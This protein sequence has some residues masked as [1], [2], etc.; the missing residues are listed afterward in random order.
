M[1]RVAILLPPA[2]PNGASSRATAQSGPGGAR[3][4]ALRVER[5]INRLEH[6]RAVATR[7]DERG[8]I[9]LGTTTAAA[10]VT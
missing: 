6:A 5:A 9:H 2:P 1:E 4:R 10:L 7:Y 8:Y 3:R